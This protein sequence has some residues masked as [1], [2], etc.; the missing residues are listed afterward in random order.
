MEGIGKRISTNMKVS[1]RVAID[2]KD[3]FY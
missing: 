3:P 1:D 2:R